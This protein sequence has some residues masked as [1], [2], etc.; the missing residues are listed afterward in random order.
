MKLEAQD[1]RQIVDSG[2][3][4]SREG[5]SPSRWLQMSTWL[6]LTNLLARHEFLF[7][8]CRTLESPINENRC[9]ILPEQ[10]SSD[11]QA[12][13]NFGIGTRDYDRMFFI[14]ATGNCLQ[15]YLVICFSHVL[16]RAL[17][18]VFFLL[19]II[20]LKPVWGSYVCRVI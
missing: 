1:R 7:T 13:E 9:D 6:L 2:R 8:C 4:F 17:F 20:R 18:L 19:Y 14:T 15:C 10:Q 3:T 16:P 5:T 12:S 11:L